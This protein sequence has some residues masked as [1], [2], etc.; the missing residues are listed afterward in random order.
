VADALRPHCDDLVV[1]PGALD[2]AGW[3][4][5]ARLAPDL[6]PA[7]AS[8]TGIHAAISAAHG[9]VVVVAWDM[10]FVPP[11]LV[12]ELLG[13]LQG[14]A[15]AVIP[16]SNGR[17]EPLCAAYAPRAAVPIG[18]A[19]R[20]GTLRI[21]EVLARLGTIV[22]MEDADLRELGD[23]ERMFFNVNT[24]RDLARAEEMAAGP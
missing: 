6:M 24:P 8:I 1:A 7:K 11:S 17:P 20:S 13:R 22:W 19:I 23:P 21:S 15:V 12:G 3:L 4:K 14:E 9:N 16:F 10:P 2:G 5:G 18:D